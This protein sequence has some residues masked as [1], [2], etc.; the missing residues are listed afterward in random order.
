MSRESERRTPGVDSKDHPANVDAANC[1]DNRD[2]LRRVGAVAKFHRVETDAASRTNAT[3]FRK[4]ISA[5]GFTYASHAKAVE[6]NT[7]AFRLTAYRLGHTMA[8]PTE[9]SAKLEILFFDLSFDKR[10]DSIIAFRVLRIDPGGNATILWK[11]LSR[12]DAAK[13]KFAKGEP[14]TDFK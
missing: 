7:Y 3:Q 13:L 9:K 10:V 1:A 2:V 8:Q 11:E 14:F 6:N 4:G 12:K 5:T